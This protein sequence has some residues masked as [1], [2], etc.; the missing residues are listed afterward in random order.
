MRFCLLLAATSSVSA[1]A[2]GWLH[3]DIGGHGLSSVSNLRLHRWL[4][5]AA[6]LWTLAVAVVLE[7][8]TRRQRRSILFRLMLGIGALLV[9]AT[10]HFGGMLVHG[11]DFFDW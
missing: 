10:G 7:T 2:L 8:D 9:S 1:V 11:D 3:A 6:C 5:T 4:G